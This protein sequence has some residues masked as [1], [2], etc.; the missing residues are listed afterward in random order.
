MKYV[1]F[2]GG[3]DSAYVVLKYILN[4]E[5]VQPIYVKREGVFNKIQIQCLNKFVTH[6]EKIKEPIFID[7]IERKRSKEIQNEIKKFDNK[8]INIFRDETT[9]SSVI[10]HYDILNTL[11]EYTNT[12]DIEISIGCEKDSRLITDMLNNIEIKNKKIIQSELYF[13]NRIVWANCDKTKRE[14]V[15]DIKNVDFDLLNFMFENTVSCR[16]ILN[17]KKTKKYCNKCIKCLEIHNSKI[18]HYINL[19][20]LNLL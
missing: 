1:A 5:T 20:R 13:M 15:E 19:N 17:Y 14:C 7:V 16:N 3:L 11:I 6:F 12:H 10:W 4:G 2:S 18:H 9:G 8:G